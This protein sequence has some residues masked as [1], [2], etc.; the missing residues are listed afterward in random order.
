[1]SNIPVDPYADDAI[2]VQ[3]ASDR[4]ITP[5]GLVV[6]V[7]TV[8]LLAVVAWGIYQNSLS[9]PE[10]GPAPSFDLPLIGQEGTFSL[11]EHRGKVVVINFWG[12]WCGPCR[13]EAPML[14]R[15]YEDYQTEGVEFVGI[16][17]KDIEADSIEYM[18]EFEITYP[19]V[20]DL[21][22]K[23]ED[24][25]RTQGVPETFI[26]D[27]NGEIVKFFFAQP[28]EADLREVIESTLESA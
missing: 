25:Y 18:D 9:Q 1:M 6:L 11:E 26:V 12:S 19:N 22:G 8:L 14:Q 17:V 2:A 15:L 21:G 7:G 24:A 27:Q 20:M 23:M 5:F 16:A 10:D 3:P 28:S 13:D 4:L